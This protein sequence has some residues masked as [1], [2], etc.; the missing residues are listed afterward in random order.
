MRRYPR[1]GG[2][3]SRRDFLRRVGGTAVALPSMAAILDACSKPGTQPIVSGTNVETLLLNPARPDHPVTLPLYEQPIPADMP[4]EQNATLKLYNWDYYMWP[5]LVRDEFEQKFSQYNVKVDIQWFYDS[6]GAIAKLSGGQVQADIFFPDPSQLTRLVIAKQLKPLQH[7][8]IPNLKAF[9]WPEFQNPFYD[10]G[11]RYSVPYTVY[12]TG[13]AYRRDHISDDAVQGLAN[14]YEV[15]W[16]PKYKGKVAIYD[17]F[18]T[19]LGLALLKNGVTDLN[20]EDPAQITLAKND[21]LNMVKATNPYIQINGIYVKMAHDDYWVGNSWSGDIVDAYL[22]YAPPNTPTS[23]WGYWYPS[24]GRGSIGSD[25]IVMP[26]NGQNPRLAHEFINFM[27]EKKNSYANFTN[28]NGYQTALTSLNP[29]TLVT[30]KNG[31]GVLH[32]ASGNLLYPSNLSQAVVQP[33]YFDNGYF[34]LEISPAAE[35]LWTDAWDEI[36]AGA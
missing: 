27:L 6:N 33:S 19:T 25:L 5:H 20:T 3:M 14:P 9:Y 29:D 34:T 12:T 28:Y 21:I 24:D 2:P 4:I 31:T 30:K 1:I 32:D 36:K 26:K 22:Y 11:W 10:Q 7:E 8:L 16:D 15:L 18:R 35:K 13:I 23:V 17:D